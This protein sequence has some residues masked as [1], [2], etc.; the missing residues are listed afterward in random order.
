MSDFRLYP[1][2]CRPLFKARPWGGRTLET[3]FGKPLPPGQEIGEAWEAADIPEGTSLIANGPLAG[4]SLT[5]VVRIWK[6]DLIGHAWKH[7]DR[8]PLLV[9]LLDAREDLSVQV[10]PGPEDCR[11]NFPEHHS[12][13]E[14]WVVL[15]A[16]P[17]GALYWGFQK[18]ATL[19]EFRTLLESGRIET[20]LRRV[21][22][23]KG[24][25][26][27]V[28]PRTVHALLRGVVLLEVQEPSDSTFRIYDYGRI[29]NGNPRP[30][31]IEEATRVMSFEWHE[32]PLI[33]PRIIPSR[34]AQRELLVD[35]DAYRME[36]WQIKG[37]FDPGQILGTARVVFCMEGDCDIQG[38]GETAPLKTGDTAIIPAALEN[39]AIHAPRGVL[40]VVSGAGGVDLLS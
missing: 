13:D 28:A 27:R 26:V 39:A 18:G 6:R 24:D 23:K 33:R 31:H 25:L 40:L 36:R 30:L 11:R 8:F 38:G 35:C 19:N 20:I 5:E 34:I 21:P 2:K 1:L 22:V 17:D 12:K 37:V 14:S 15:D 7:A 3:L 16:E 4:Q 9:K 29:V 32:E 10:H